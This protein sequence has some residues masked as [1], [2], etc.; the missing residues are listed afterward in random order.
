MEA[1]QKWKAEK[2]THLPGEKPAQE[3]EEESI[4]SVQNQE[5]TF[6]YLTHPTS[7]CT[8]DLTQSNLRC[9]VSEHSVQ[10]V[11]DLSLHSPMMMRIGM[12]WR[13]RR[14]ESRFLPMFQ[15]HLKRR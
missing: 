2:E 9:V 3:E 6:I 15:S 11:L 10:G 12:N 13:K 4:Y 14:A 1:V 8:A 7:C 5:V